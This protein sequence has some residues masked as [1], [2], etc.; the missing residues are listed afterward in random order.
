MD[1]IYSMLGLAA[2]A[3]KVKSGMFQTE[4]AIRDGSAC[5]VIMAEDAGDN[6][7]KTLRDKCSYYE[8]PLAVYGNSDALGHA[9]GKENRVCAAVIDSGFSVSIRKLMG[10]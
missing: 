4:E 10:D 1:R 2:R 6:S 7:A 5:L 8:V 9:I 3:G